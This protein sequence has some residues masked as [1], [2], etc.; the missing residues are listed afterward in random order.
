MNNQ[1]GENEDVLLAKL[2]QANPVS[3]VSVRSAHDSAA[4]AQL[5]EI[6]MSS[7][8]EPIN[9]GAYPDNHHDLK[10]RQKVAYRQPSRSPWFMAAAASL[11]LLLVTSAVLFWP[12]STEPALAAVQSAAAEVQGAESGK[13]IT[14]LEVSDG[15]FSEAVEVE[16]LFNGQD[17]AVKPLPNQELG[18]DEFE[19]RLIDGVSYLKEGEQWQSVE[20]PDF[21]ASEASKAMTEMLNPTTVLDVVDVISDVE[22][23]G[24]QEIA[25]VETD[26]Y[27]SVVA[28][29]DIDV[30]SL[31]FL[32]NQQ[33]GL[34][35]VLGGE[36][37]SIKQSDLP[38]VDGE[39]TID[40]N[41]DDDGLMRKISFAGSPEFEGES[42]NVDAEIVFSDLNNDIAID[43][44]EASETLDLLGSFEESD[45]RV[46]I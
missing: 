13:V 36:S 30:D 38:A 24:K 42:I 31:N 18:L 35:T 21:L 6:L 46:D 15:E 28:L 32:L 26:H 33:S 14:T 37:A 11:V 2:L 3:D 22:T 9:I 12:N 40:I 29:A 16:I 44:P 5:E 17:I 10:D 39:I 8:N 1:N 7:R 41:I 25:G 27:R 34:S 43:A 4:Q 45:N 23:V 19:V 20:L